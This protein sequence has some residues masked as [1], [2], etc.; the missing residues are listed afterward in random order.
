MIQGENLL[1]EIPDSRQTDFQNDQRGE[2]VGGIN[3]SIR[4]LEGDLSTYFL[5]FMYDV[6]AASS[7]LA[8]LLSL[9]Q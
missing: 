4:W 9:E 7:I 1:F 5:P 3:D 6:K 2:G 8:T